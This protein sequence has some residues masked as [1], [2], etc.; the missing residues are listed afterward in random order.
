MSIYKI[1]NI[2]H[3]ATKRDV[4]F[5]STLEIEYVEDMVKKVITFKPNETV[6]LTVGSLPLSVHKL[7]VK[8][9]ITVVEVGAAE[10]AKSIND[11]KPK[12]EK[13]VEIE[14]EPVVEIKAIPQKKKIGRKQD[15]GDEIDS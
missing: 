7:R 4:K 15:G 11:S 1:V 8:N 9:L 13:I 10:L 3:L 12:I 6:F 2:T 5:N 14:A